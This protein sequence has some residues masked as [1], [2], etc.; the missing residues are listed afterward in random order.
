MMTNPR[1]HHRCASRFCSYTVL[2]PYQGTPEKTD[3]VTDDATTLPAA[4]KQYVKPGAILT[5]NPGQYAELNINVSVGD[6]LG[7]CNMEGTAK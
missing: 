5:L 7:V 4:V 2:D 3:G 6:G 1:L